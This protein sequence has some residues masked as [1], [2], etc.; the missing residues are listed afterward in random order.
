M[1]RLLLLFILGQ[2]V[3]RWGENGRN[4]RKTPGIPS[5]R[6]WPVS[7]VPRVGSNPHQIQLGEVNE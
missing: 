2:S 3:L 1:N 4:P 5:T 7:H 6:T